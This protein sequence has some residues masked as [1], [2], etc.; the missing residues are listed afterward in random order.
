MGPVMYLPTHEYK[1]W[2]LIPVIHLSFKWRKD[3]MDCMVGL[4]YF[5][6]KKLVSNYLLMY[7]QG[8]R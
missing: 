1:K 4:F 6:E 2:I 7:V 8:P 5:N 3:A